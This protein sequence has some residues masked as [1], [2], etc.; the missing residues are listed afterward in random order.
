[1][2][3]LRTMMLEE[4]Q[5]RNYADTTIRHYLRF[6]ER[7]A[8]HFGKSPDKLG[9]EHLRTYQAYLLKK[10][11]LAPATVEHLI[12]ATATNARGFLLPPNRKRLAPANRR[13][14]TSCASRFRCWLAVIQ[15]LPTESWKMRV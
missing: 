9:P 14:R 11:K 15:A 6:V 2:T 5:A 4:L 12:T 7:L 10:R 8:Q 3:H 13:P 1:V